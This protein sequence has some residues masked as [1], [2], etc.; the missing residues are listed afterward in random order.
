MRTNA[1]QIRRARTT[2]GKRSHESNYEHRKVL[3]K[4]VFVCGKGEVWNTQFHDVTEDMQ[5]Y[6]PKVIT[7]PR[8]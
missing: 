4:R 8:G 7:P 1:G 3:P 5:T 6:V 2:F